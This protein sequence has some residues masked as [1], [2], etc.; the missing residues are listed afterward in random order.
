MLFD[1][2]R[3]ISSHHNSNQ[4]TSKRTRK[5][6]TA[7]TKIAIINY[8]AESKC[9]IREAAVT[10]DVDKSTVVNAKKQAASLK[11]IEENNMDLK[12]K[13]IE[14]ESET[15]LPV[16]RWFHDTRSRGFAISGTIIQEVA[17]K[18]SLEAGD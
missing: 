18:F 5:T 16:Y 1:H 8:I 4:Q 13:R 3:Q 11:F 17:L 15:N 14:K 9:S 10:F 2:L 7:E 6:S 12:I